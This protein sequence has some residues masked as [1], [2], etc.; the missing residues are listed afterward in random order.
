ML[1]F[2]R[3]EKQEVQK[4]INYKIESEQQKVE[5][6]KQL[7]YKIYSRDVKNDIYKIENTNEFYITKDVLYVIYAYGNESETSEMDLII[8]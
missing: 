3:L 4:Q 7:G 5:D 1:K 6:L 2:E 8:I